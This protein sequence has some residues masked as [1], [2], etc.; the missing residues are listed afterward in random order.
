MNLERKTTSIVQIDLE[1]NFL[2]EKLSL[3]RISRRINEEGWRVSEA[4]EKLILSP[5][6]AANGSKGHLGERFDGKLS[7]K[8]ATCVFLPQAICVT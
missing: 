6:L 4:F 1:P 5:F 2:K 8:H 7:L 3:T